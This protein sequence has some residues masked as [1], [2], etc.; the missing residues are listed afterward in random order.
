MAEFLPVVDAD[1]NVIGKKERLLVH[2]DGDL[3][4]VAHV[5]VYNE[6]GEVLCQKRA[7]GVEISPNT[8]DCIVGGHVEYGKSYE[9]TALSEASEEYGLSIEENRLAHLFKVRA[10]IYTK[11]AKCF[12]FVDSFALRYDGEL[13]EIQ[14]NEKEVSE[15]QW[16]S[17]QQLEAI[18]AG[19]DSSKKFFGF[20]TFDQAR[21]RITELL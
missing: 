10:D 1:D 16:L 14:F 19:K 17:F 5:W 6:K 2:R 13:S 7:A 4:R 8:W 3:H 9:Q 18:K 11:E 21:S 15:L 20:L 12:K